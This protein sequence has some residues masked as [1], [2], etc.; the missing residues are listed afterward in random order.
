VG[1]LKGKL[2]EPPSL[3]GSPGCPYIVIITRNF[4]QV[5]PENRQTF[6]FQVPLSRKSCPQPTLFSK[7]AVERGIP[8]QLRFNLLLSCTPPHFLFVKRWR[9]RKAKVCRHLWVYNLE[10]SKVGLACGRGKG[11]WQLGAWQLG[12]EGPGTRAV[13]CTAWK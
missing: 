11:I 6:S 7:M 3:W 12:A 1:P 5:S 13:L 4:W 9:H 10:Q 2:A 8:R